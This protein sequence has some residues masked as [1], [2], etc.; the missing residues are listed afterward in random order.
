VTHAHPYLFHAPGLPVS[1]IYTRGGGEPLVVISPDF[2]LCSILL[3]AFAAN[4]VIV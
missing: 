1:S 3:L 2:S 4:R